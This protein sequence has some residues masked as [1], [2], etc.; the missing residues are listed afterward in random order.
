MGNAKLY[1]V[2]VFGRWPDRFYVVDL[3]TGTRYPN[4]QFPKSFENQDIDYLNSIVKMIPE[5]GFPPGNGYYFLEKGSWPF[6]GICLAF[7]ASEALK[8]RMKDFENEII[9]AGN[10]NTSN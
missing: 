8:K 1:E 9:M 6:H 3:Q 2:H 7:K 10:A 5:D 4:N